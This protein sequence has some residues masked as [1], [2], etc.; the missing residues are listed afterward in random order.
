MITSAYVHIPFCRRKCYY[1]SFVSFAKSELREKYL[2]ALLSEI[3][4]RYKGEKLKTL[5]IGGGTPSLMSAESI[6]KIIGCFDFEND[7][8]ITC[9]A[10]PEQLSLQWLKDIKSAAVNRLSLGV[11]SFDDNLLRTIGRKHSVKDV[12]TA[13]ENAR[14]AGFENINA[15]LIYGL[16]NQEMS[17]F[18][19]SVIT[20]CELGFE[21][22]SS[23]GLKIEENSYFYGNMPDNLPDED[24]Q[25]AMYLKLIEITEKYG[26]EHYEISNFAKKGFESKHNLNYWNDSNYYGFGCAASG[27]ENNIRYSHCRTIGEYCQNPLALLEKEVL[28]P[29]MR[30]EETIFLGLRKKEGIKVKE[31]NQNFGIDFETKYADI[32]K[33]YGEYFVRTSDG[34]AFSDKGF[35]VSNV[36]LSEFIE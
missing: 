32:L 23:Y 6:G 2:S 31:I 18:S 1:C 21:H 14:R 7:A 9:E 5:Y 4:N 27:F 25:A 20:A 15:D 24:M 36:I 8:E 26:F 11:Q 34:Y 28:S 30:L 10:N 3:K 19:A 12:F 29:Q 35:L 13:L 33:K 16:P 22:L 17:D